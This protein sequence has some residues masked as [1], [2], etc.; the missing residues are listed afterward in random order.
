MNLLPPATYVNQAGYH[1]LY[2]IKDANRA[3]EL[4][5]INVS[6]FPNWYH[7]HDS[8]GEAYMVKGETSTAIAYYERSLELNPANQN[9]KKQLQAV[10]T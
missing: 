4:F 2:Q 7:A 6:N 3:I 8:L 5:K 10:R 1:L 9:A